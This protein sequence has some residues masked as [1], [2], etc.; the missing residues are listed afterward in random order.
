MVVT[1]KRHIA[2]AKQQRMADLP[3][4]RVVPSPPFTHTGVD[5]FGPFRIKRARSEV[6]RWGCLFT[7]MSTR[8]IHIEKL[9]DLSTESFLNALMRF[10][11]RQGK[12]ISIISDNGGN[13]V[14]GNS[15]LAKGIKEW[16]QALINE[17]LIQQQITWKFNPP[18]SSHR[19]G[20]WER[21]IRT[22]RKVLSI[23]LNQQ[24]VSDDVLNTVL[25]QAEEVVNN[26]PITK[27]SEDP[28]DP[29]VLRPKDLLLYTHRSVTPNL[30]S[31]STDLYKNSFKQAQYSIDL[32]WT[33]WIL[34]YIPELQRR[35]KW[36]KIKPNL[37][38]GN[39]VL[40]IEDQTHRNCW[41]LGIVKR[42]IK[43]VDG[44]VRT[45][46]IKSQGKDMIRDVN[47]IVLLEGDL[48]S[49]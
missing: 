21:Q 16:N 32:F 28:N 31:F 9:D 22:I 2:K 17:K 26:R 33:K 45:V 13:F 42:A 19:G 36:R 3:I 6:K 7:C 35:Q 43:D 8:A 44:L 12:P 27:L 39:V 25:I 34:Y 1:C 47:K 38:E 20:V 4:E 49:E 29:S 46:E 5:C 30:K 14:K 18:Y 23:T 10:I 15:D 37:K 24:K 41:P 40:L 11:A 48:D